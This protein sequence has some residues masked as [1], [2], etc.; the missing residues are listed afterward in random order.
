M[1]AI[2]VREIQEIAPGRWGEKMESEKKFD[3]VESRLVFPPPRRYRCLSGGHSWNTLIKEY[4]YDSLAAL[5]ADWEKYET[6]PEFQALF[7]EDRGHTTDHWWELYM[8]VP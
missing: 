8:P 5:E 2:V 3:A 4:E 6:E 1:A 7:A